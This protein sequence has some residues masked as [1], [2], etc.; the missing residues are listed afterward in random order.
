MRRV[1]VE[2]FQRR[3]E[4]GVFSIERLFESVRA[5]LPAEF[6]VHVHTNRFHSRGVWPRLFDA[7]RAGWRA[8]AVNHV[9]GDVHY[10]TW[11]LPRER[12]LLTI[13]DCVS[14]ERLH[15]VRRELLW[16]LWYWLPLQRAA[17]VSVV[18][19][20]TRRALLDWVP[21]TAADIRVIPPPVPANFGPWP[22]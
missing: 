21:N 22:A 9:L 6:E 19:E 2:Q 11:F 7:L 4:A 5:A 3:A 18:S 13:H 8:G 20:Y 14:L 15:G 16:L 10:L 17:I 12:T 1:V